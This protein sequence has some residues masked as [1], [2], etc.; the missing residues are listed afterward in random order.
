MWLCAGQQARLSVIKEPSGDGHRMKLAG[1]VLL[2][3]VPLL[4]ADGVVSARGQFMGAFWASERDSKVAHVAGHRRQWA[5]MGIV[6]VAMLAVTTTGI[7]AFGVLLSRSGEGILVSIALGLFVL[8]VASMLAAA[9]VLFGSVGVAA[10]A[11]RSAGTTPGWLE[12]MWAAVTWAEATYIVLSSLAYVVFGIGMFRAGF[13][14]TWVA[15]ASVAIGTVSVVGM[16]AMPARF[17]FPQLPLLVP[18]VLGFA[19]MT[20]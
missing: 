1:V 8:G 5:T 6:W 11:R 12:P 4:A 7:S 2:L 10:Q 13:P 19:L 15:W 14:A 20:S 9:F 16:I 17:G 3:L 18:I